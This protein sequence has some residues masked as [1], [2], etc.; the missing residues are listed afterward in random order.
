[1]SKIQDIKNKINEK[2][3]SL[4]S[5]MAKDCLSK[6]LAIDKP[7]KI[8]A[9]PEGDTESKNGMLALNQRKLNITKEQ[10]EILEDLM[11]ENELVEFLKTSIEMNELSKDTLTNYVGKAWKDKVNAQDSAHT[12][13]KHNKNSDRAKEYA[14][15][16][17]KRNMGLDHAV[18]R[19]PEDQQGIV[20]DIL[21]D[22]ESD[23]IAE[24]ILDELSKGTLG[25]YI[26][27][28][29]RDYGNHIYSIGVHRND[30]SKQGAEIK[31]NDSKI[32]N[33]RERG[34]N[35]AL[36]KLTKE[37]QDKVNTA[38]DILEDL[39]SEEFVKDILSLDEISKKTM[40]SYVKKAGFSLIGIGSEKNDIQRD[41]R[42]DRN[43][44]V[45]NTARNNMEKNNKKTALK[46]LSGI[47]RA[48]S[49]L[50]KEDQDEVYPIMEESEYDMMLQEILSIDELSKEKLGVYVK[51]AR[52]DF[53]DRKDDHR[54]EFRSIAKR[55]IKGITR[56]TK[57]LAQEQVETIVLLLAELDSEIE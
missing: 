55:R 31:S 1:M 20:Y 38:L 14:R 42:D 26:A 30:R 46:R 51:R 44:G 22:I 13:N 5:E 9:E 52:G 17:K 19:L 32:A 47:S 48:V 33:K 49:K 24:E 40:G 39:E 11:I 29:T 37:D 27:K 25:R 54:E 45:L 35:K 28:S 2:V 21:E 15:V 43:S 50:T 36:S 41:R 16:A 3:E 53:F 34:I 7:T 12:E 8:V 23:Y 10:Y 18:K 57:K 4:L 56:A 6:K